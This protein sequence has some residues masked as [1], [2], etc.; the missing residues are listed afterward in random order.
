MVPRDTRKW[1]PLG[2]SRDSV[3]WVGTNTP[4]LPIG[5]SDDVMQGSK[6]GDGAAGGRLCRGRPPWNSSE[7]PQETAGGGSAENCQGE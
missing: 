6:G 5:K 3:L 2:T 4:K 7:G 1:D